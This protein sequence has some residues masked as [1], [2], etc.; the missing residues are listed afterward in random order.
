VGIF[1]E[2]IWLNATSEAIDQ[3]LFRRICAICRWQRRTRASCPLGSHL[4]ALLSGD[5]LA[6]RLRHPRIEGSKSAFCNNQLPARE[7]SRLSEASISFRA[8]DS[9]LLHL[10]AVGNPEG[11]EVVFLQL[12]GSL[13]GLSCRAITKGLCSKC[14]SPHLLAMVRHH[15]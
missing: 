1:F 9:E 7:W 4:F 10:I 15:G 2:E 8:L 12:W 13:L 6:E 5:S 14:L 3:W 11:R